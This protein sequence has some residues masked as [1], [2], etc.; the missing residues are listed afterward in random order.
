MDATSKVSDRPFLD[1]HS[2]ATVGT[3]FCFRLTCLTCLP[4]ASSTLVFLKG[5]WVDAFDTWWI[6]TARRL[7]PLDTEAR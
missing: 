4:T 3:M 5:H 7:S 1:S 6:I 2:V